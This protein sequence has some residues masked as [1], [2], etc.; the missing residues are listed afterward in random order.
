MEPA[1]QVLV[2]QTSVQSDAD[3]LLHLA[4]DGFSA[5]VGA[6]CGVGVAL[7]VL[8]SLLLPLNECWMPPDPAA[9]AGHMHWLTACPAVHCCEAIAAKCLAEAHG[10]SHGQLIASPNAA[11]VV[12]A[13]SPVSAAS[14]TRFVWLACV[15]QIFV[16]PILKK[17]INTAHERIDK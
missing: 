3:V 15:L 9:P 8:A 12:S 17:R 11:G 5:W 13:A 2:W 6:V 7:L 4:A 16:M 1:T 14:G 10:A